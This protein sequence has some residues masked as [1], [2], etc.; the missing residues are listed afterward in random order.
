MS[1]QTES[2][3]EGEK[4]KCK[5]KYMKIPQIFLLTGNINSFEQE[6]I[7]L[8]T[9]CFFRYRLSRFQFIFQI[10]KYTRE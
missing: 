6:K 3:D 7:F 8:I 4:N 5:K 10:F 2:L 9:L 1:Y